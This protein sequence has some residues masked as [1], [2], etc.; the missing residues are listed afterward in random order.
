[1]ERALIKKL[2]LEYQDFATQIHFVR[3]DINVDTDKCNV[4]V[5]LRR[6]GKSY[7]LYQT[8]HDLI[9]SGLSKQSVLYFN[10]EDDRLGDMSLVDLDTIKTCYE[11]LFAEKPVF[12]LDE[13]QIVDGWER[14]ARRLADTG[15]L[16]FIT[17][18]NAKMLSSEIA[19]TLGGRYIMTEVFPLSFK[20][21][22]DFRSVELTNGWEYRQ[23]SE[24]K[25]ELNEYFHFGGLP[26]VATALK[27]FKRQRLSSLFDRIYFGDLIARN[28]LRKKNSLKTLIRKVSESIGQPVTYNRLASVVTSTGPALKSET[29][30]EYLDYMKQAWLMIQIENFSGKFTERLSYSKYYFVDNGLISLFREDALGELLENM[31]AVH[32]RRRY[33]SD[34]YYYKHNIEVDFYIPSE[35][36]AIQVSYTVADDKTRQREQRAIETINTQYPL[37]RAMIITYDEEDVYTLDS[38]LRVEVL[39]LW[40]W[41]LS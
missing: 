16:V 32:L 5:G 11:E 23:N 21:Y 18:S 12:F 4:F 22:L 10:F 26:E 31:V 13:I 20:E 2:I 15:Y 33:G 6:V 28:N 24:I 19:S 41:M 3:R 29:V 39:P 37:R 17:G 40:K 25:R 1:M 34:L 30:G 14:F 36:M 7:L 9:A 35:E 27:P 38:G 8:M